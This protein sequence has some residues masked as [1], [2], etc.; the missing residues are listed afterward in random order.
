MLATAD[1]VPATCELIAGAQ[2]EVVESITGTA[3]PR[4]STKS[5]AD[6]A[7]AVALAAIRVN[8]QATP[9]LEQLAV[10]EMP[11]A[12]EAGH[13]AVRCPPLLA[14]GGLAA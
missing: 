14:R 3:L 4:T 12:E 5:L 11:S 9:L 13:A 2:P 7:Q 8:R 1:Q 10:R 6:Q